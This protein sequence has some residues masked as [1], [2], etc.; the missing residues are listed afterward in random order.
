MQR[1]V[2]VSVILCIV[3]FGACSSTDQKVADELVQSTVSELPFSSVA[4]PQ[5]VLIHRQI[6]E[7]RGKN[8]IKNQLGVDVTKLDCPSAGQEFVALKRDETLD[9][10]FEDETLR[11]GTATFGLNAAGDDIELRGTRNIVPGPVG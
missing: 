7:A 5:G 6:L 9:C 1:A 4:P 3:L 8:L 2:S 11:S 10:E